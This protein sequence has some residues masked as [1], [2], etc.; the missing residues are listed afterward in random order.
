MIRFPRGVPLVVLAFAVMAMQGCDASINSAGGG[1]FDPTVRQ[2]LTVTV[3][4]NSTGQPIPGATVRLYQKVSNGAEYLTSQTAGPDG[5]VTFTKPADGQYLMYG[6]A[7]GYVGVSWFASVISGAVLAPDIRLTPLSLLPDVAQAQIPSTGGSVSTLPT[8]GIG[9]SSLD[10]GA[11]VLPT[12]ANVT[13]AT[14]QG[15]QVPVTPPGEVAVSA[16]V[17]TS[18]QALT[19]SATIH[20]GL[21]FDLPDGISIPIYAWNDSSNSWVPI[22]TG[23]T[24][25]GQVVADISSLGSLSALAT[26]LPRHSALQPDV[27]LSSRVLGPSDGTI[28]TT[29]YIPTLSFPSSTNYSDKT[30]NWIRGTLEQLLGLTFGQAVT[31]HLVRDASKSQELT[32]IR[33]FDLYTLT[34]Q[35]AGPKLTRLDGVA[36]TSYDFFG[37]VTT[38]TSS[39]QDINHNSGFGTGG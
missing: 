4:D 25:N 12:G 21:P 2:D 18:D 36:S 11:G 10:F 38:Q 24:S 14:L 5:K 35:F 16:V 23:T 19:G 27:T 31:V 8:S 6:S 22:A 7:T 17:V 34:V 26:F 9:Q 29:T 30:K 32:V 39:I 28:I 33:H 20:L 15:A 13:I 3:Y 37:Q 1:Q